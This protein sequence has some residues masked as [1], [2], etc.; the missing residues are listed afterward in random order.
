MAPQGVRGA[1]GKRKPPAGST[2]PARGLRLA[3]EPGSSVSAPPCAAAGFPVSFSRPA[4]PPP[5]RPGLPGP[6]TASSDL[7]AVAASA[8]LGTAPAS[9]LRCRRPQ[10]LGPWLAPSRG[11]PLLGLSPLPLRRFR[12]GS[13]RLLHFRWRMNTLT[14]QV[15]KRNTFLDR[16]ARNGPKRASSTPKRARIDGNGTPVHQLCTPVGPRS[17]PVEV[18]NTSV[19]AP[20]TP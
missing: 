20:D 7:A 15:G 14:P 8:E 16:A 1:G 2:L 17:T 13:L 11:C 19:E 3:G 18:P 10:R 4:F 9:G 6:S 12:S 5:G